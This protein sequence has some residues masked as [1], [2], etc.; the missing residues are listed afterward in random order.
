MSTGL[1]LWAKAK[2]TMTATF[3]PIATKN[4]MEGLTTSRPNTSRTCLYNWC[5]GIG[6]FESCRFG[7]HVGVKI[8]SKPLITWL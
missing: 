2:L 5:G 8:S 1:V 6:T 4:V 3:G 7:I